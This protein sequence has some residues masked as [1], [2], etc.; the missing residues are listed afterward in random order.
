MLLSCPR[1]TQDESDGLARKSIADRVERITGGNA[2]WSSGARE[3]QALLDGGRHQEGRRDADHHHGSD[4][5]ASERSDRGL[6]KITESLRDG[7]DGTDEA[8]KHLLVKILKIV[9]EKSAAGAEESAADDVKET[10]DGA[11]ET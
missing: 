5:T 11:A 7:T 3:D 10:V 2:G 6:E 9:D 4:G 8:P 1:F